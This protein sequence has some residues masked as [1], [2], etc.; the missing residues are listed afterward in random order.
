[1]SQFGTGYDQPLI[2][3]YIPSEVAQFCKNYPLEDIYIRRFDELDEVLMEKLTKVIAEFGMTDCLEIQ[4][5]RIG[6]PML[7]AEMQKRFEAIEHEEKEKDLAETRK[8]T[9]K[10]KLETQ[11]Q[12]AKMLSQ[13]AQ[14]E[15]RIQLETK[16]LSARKAAEIQDIENEMKLKQAKSEAEGAQVKQQQVA[17]GLAATIAAFNGNTEHMLEW[18]RTSAYWN[19]TNKV[20]YFADSSNHMPKTFVGQAKEGVVGAA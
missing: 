15:A 20:Y 4:K 7:S 17:T 16:V 6:R 19:S 8:Q 13:Q 10:V 9:D 2:F 11:L 12:S 3:D 5:V 1:V 18:H 14:E